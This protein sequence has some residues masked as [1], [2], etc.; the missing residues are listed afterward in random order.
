MREQ[1]QGKHVLMIGDEV[2]DCA[3][4]LMASSSVIVLANGLRLKRPK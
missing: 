4:L 1:E 3:A 2:N